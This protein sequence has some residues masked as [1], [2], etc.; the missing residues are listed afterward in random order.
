M[1]YSL[2]NRNNAHS[3]YAVENEPQ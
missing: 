1:S 3:S 2:N